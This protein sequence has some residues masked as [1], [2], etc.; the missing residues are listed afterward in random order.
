MTHYATEHKHNNS[1]MLTNLTCIVSSFNSISLLTILICY[2]FEH[3]TFAF[4][5]NRLDKLKYAG[6]PS[7]Q[8]RAND[9]AYKKGHKRTIQIVFDNYN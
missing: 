2:I 6:T 3:C 9:N 8:F 4:T 1:R 7:S 5:V